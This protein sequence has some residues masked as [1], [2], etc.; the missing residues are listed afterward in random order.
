MDS[1][2][3]A[4]QLEYLKDHNYSTLSVQDLVVA[5]KEKR[6][7]KG[8]FVVITLDDGYK[9]AYEYAF[10]LAKKYKMIINLMLPTGLIG[11]PAYLSW[12]QVKEMKS[13]GLVFVYNHTD[14]HY[15]LAKGPE[16]KVLQEINLAQEKLAKELGPNLSKIITYP[17]G[18]YNLDTIRIA[19][20]NGFIAGLTT[21]GGVSQCNTFIMELRRQR[22]GNRNLSDYYL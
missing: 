14:S 8:K 19:E 6:E 21:K 17:Y 3:F 9:D 16:K 15:P 11:D 13:S 22:I 18:S 4:K 7:L 1:D 5:L 10:P 2:Y 20:D 12:G